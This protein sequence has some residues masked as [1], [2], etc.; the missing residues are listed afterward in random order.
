MV[1]AKAAPLPPALPP[2]LLNSL[3]ARTP[4]HR[5]HHHHPGPADIG[6]DQRQ[7]DRTEE[8]RASAATR[9]GGTAGSFWETWE[10]R[11]QERRCPFGGGNG[12]GGVERS[13]RAGCGI[14]RSQTGDSDAEEPARPCRAWPRNCVISNHLVRAIYA[15]TYAFFHVV[16]GRVP[17]DNKA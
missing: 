12:D 2:A 1:A 5:P 13:K 15:C 8:D 9:G 4:W 17:G 11:P 6:T 14:G 7:P 16:E 10:D 3:P